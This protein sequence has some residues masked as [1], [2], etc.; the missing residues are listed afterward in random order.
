MKMLSQSEKYNR[1]LNLLRKSKP[2]IG[3]TEEIEAEVL[4]SISKKHKS[5]YV[6]SDV[7]GFLFSWIYIR[8][9]RRALIAASVSIIVIF[10]WQQYTILKQINYLS[11]QTIIIERVSTPDQAELLE[12]RIL[13][14]L[15]G[16]G[17]NSRTLKMSD[18]QINQFIDSAIEMQGKYKDLMNLINQDP[19]LKKYIEKKLMEN[20]RA[21]TKL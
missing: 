4:K 19:E 9:V 14:K 17:I 8:W 18:K 13:S 1:L 11:R 3:S 15:S 5:D 16:Q 10:V 12:K 2:R 20:E 7:I 21:K 6:L